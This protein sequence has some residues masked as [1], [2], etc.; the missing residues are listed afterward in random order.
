MLLLRSPTQLGILELYTLTANG[1]LAIFISSN[2]SNPDP[3]HF[4][5]MS[6]GVHRSNVFNLSLQIGQFDGR[7][8][9][10]LRRGS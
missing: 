7:Q 10:L 9:H 5:A 6:S 3:K 1:Y 2:V 8:R 4:H